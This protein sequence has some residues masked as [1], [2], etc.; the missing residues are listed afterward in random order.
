[1][2]SLHLSTEGSHTETALLRTLFNLKLAKAN[3]HSEYCMTHCR[4][5][6][7]LDNEVSYH[8]TLFRGAAQWEVFRAISLL[9]TNWLIERKPTRASV[10]GKLL[11]NPEQLFN[12]VAFDQNTA[13]LTHTKTWA[14]LA[15]I[16]Y[17]LDNDNS[18]AQTQSNIVAAVTDAEHVLTKLVDS[19]CLET[20]ED[21]KVTLA[22][23]QL[24]K[25]SY[26]SRI[27]ESFKKKTNAPESPA[28]AS[29]RNPWI[30]FAMSSDIPQSDTSDRSLIP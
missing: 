13:S 5:K 6:P 27:P 15:L 10:V 26:Q 21:K 9:T 3:F 23:E 2:Y 1:M 28:F 20:N 12:V 18:A 8:L 29:R 24:Y 25:I 17:C 22:L 19:Q 14:Q 30:D 7:Q 16:F 4:L 11:V